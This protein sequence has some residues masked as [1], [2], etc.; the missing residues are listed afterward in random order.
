MTLSKLDLLKRLEGLLQAL[1]VFFA[2]NSKVF[3]EFQKLTNLINNKSNKL[4]KN[5]VKTCW[6]SMV[7]LAKDIYVEYHLLIIKMHTKSS[8]SEVVQKKL[9][10]LCDVEFILWVPLCLSLLECVH[11]FIKVTQ[12]KNVFV[13][14]FVDF[15]KVA[16]QKLYR[17]YYDLIAKYEGSNFEDFNSIEVLTNEY[18]LLS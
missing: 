6:I 7:F 12:N 11:V 3:L 10:A 15:V 1:H 17:L 16:Q 14:D 13:Y 9:N 8:K 2:H 18:L 5:H 4:F